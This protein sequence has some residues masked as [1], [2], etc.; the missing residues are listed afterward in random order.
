MLASG[1]TRDADRGRA[2]ERIGQSLSCVGHIACLIAA[3]TIAGGHRLFA[4]D[5]D[6]EAIARL[7]PLELFV[8]GEL[9]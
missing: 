7:S 2:S 1:T 4:S 9:A 3:S 8:P 6:F 5:R